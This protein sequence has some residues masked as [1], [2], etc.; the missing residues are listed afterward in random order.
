MMHFFYA[1]LSTEE[2]SCGL[3]SLAR[4][5]TEKLLKQRAMSFTA[6]SGEG[7]Q[8]C[9]ITLIAFQ[10]FKL[11]SLFVTLAERAPGRR[12]VFATKFQR[13]FSHETFREARKKQW[14]R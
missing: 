10:I 5:P 3:A 12:L 6:L 7:W 1:D 13:P 2:Q 4:S 9:T 14:Q 11:C 8:S